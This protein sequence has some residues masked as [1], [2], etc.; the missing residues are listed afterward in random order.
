MCAHAR[1]H[2]CQQGVLRPQ[3]R[4]LLESSCS[5]QTANLL[6]PGMDSGPA[7]PHKVDGLIRLAS[8]SSGDTLIQPSLP[9][10]PM[11]LV[12]KGQFWCIIS[13]SG[14]GYQ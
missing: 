10:V 8:S 6:G 1:V 4:S 13:D 5:S 3:G 14:C 2:S 11:H 7:G 12:F 9:V